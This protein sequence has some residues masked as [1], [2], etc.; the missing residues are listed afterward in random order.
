M[1]NDSLA[2][3]EFH[4]EQGPVLESLGIPIGIVE[5]IAGQTRGEFTFLGR[6]NHA[7]TTPMNLRHDAMSAAAEW[8]LEVERVAK[9]EKDWSPRWVALL[10]LRTPRMSLL[11]RCA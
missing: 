11:V 6:A 5:G 2:Y 9:R 4:I 1:K 7:G 3:L 10:P 8:I